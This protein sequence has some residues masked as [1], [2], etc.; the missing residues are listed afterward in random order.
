VIPFLPSPAVPYVRFSLL[1]V[2]RWK[3]LPPR[4][5]CDTQA[6]HYTLVAPVPRGPWLRGVMLSTSI[7][8]NPA[9]SASLMDSFRLHLIQAYTESLCHSRID[10]DCTSDLP[11][12]TL[13]FLP[14]MPPSLPRQA[15]SLLLSVSS[16]NAS[17]F[18]QGAEARHPLHCPRHFLSRYAGWTASL[19]RLQ[20]SFYT[21]A[22]RFARP[23]EMA[24]FVFTRVWN[25]Y[26]R[27]FPYLV[28]LIRV[29]YNYLSEQTIPRAGLS[30]AG[31]TALWAARTPDWVRPT[32]CE[33]SRYR[34]GASSARVLPHEPALCLHIQKGN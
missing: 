14:Y 18:A 17:V 22:C 15:A 8:A 34:V 21:T 7:I 28:A 33:P 31:I 11:Q 13:W 26:F 1:I 3:P 4:H 10:P 30:P 27:A 23:T 25:F 9:S 19:T 24:P 6:H 20:C 12:F 2:T 32:N 5:Y 29:G 16:R